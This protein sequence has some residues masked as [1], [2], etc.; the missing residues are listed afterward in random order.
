MKY[1]IKLDF[2]FFFQLDA[3]DNEEISDGVLVR[4]QSQQMLDQ[5]QNDEPA[6]VRIPT[7]YGTK[8]SSESEED[9]CE[10]I[11]KTLEYNDRILAENSTGGSNVLEGKRIS[12]FCD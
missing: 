7:S 6:F 4:L 11:R 2:T 1:S 12:S 9:P 10:S 5:I 3:G 8:D